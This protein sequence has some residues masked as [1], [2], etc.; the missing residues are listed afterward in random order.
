MNLASR[1]KKS[2]GLL[3][4]IFIYFSAV[5]QERGNY[6]FDS[7]PALPLEK[8]ISKPDGNH[9]SAKGLGGIGGVYFEKT[10]RPAQN[11]EII[12]LTFNYDSTNFDGQRFTLK[13]NDRNIKV[14]VFDWILIPIANYVNSEFNSCFTYFGELKDKYAEKFVLDND[15]HILNYHPAFYNSLLGLRLSDM[16]LLL[17]YDFAAEVPQ[18][19]WN[20]YTWRW[21][22]SFLCN[23]T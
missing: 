6:T 20:L 15:G 8:N 17:M 10:A 2:T 1:F 16:D 14:P 9:Y 18:K 7:V 11:M 5:A 21:R 23:T 12:E 4:F 3:F 22:G 13:I 19:K